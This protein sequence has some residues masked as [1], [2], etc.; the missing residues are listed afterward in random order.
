MKHAA[1]T[2][3]I[4]SRSSHPAWVRGLKQLI[5]CL[6]NDKAIVAPRVGAWIETYHNILRRCLR[7]VA[8]RVG[9]WI[10][11]W[12]GVSLLV[13]ALVAPRVGAWI[14][15]SGYI[16]CRIRYTVAPRV[17]AWIETCRLL[18]YSQPCQSH[19]AWVRGLK[20]ASGGTA[21]L[22]VSRTPCGCVD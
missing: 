6:G 7:D 20:P 22:T 21:T 17:G 1:Y 14:E 10:E 11:T 3:Y 8:P 19:P 18:P 9:A 15:T 12:I 13:V 4:P 2:K 5:G 16:T